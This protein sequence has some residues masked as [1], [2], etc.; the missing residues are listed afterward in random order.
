VGPTGKCSQCGRA[1][2]FGIQ[3]Y[4]GIQDQTFEELLNHPLRNDIKNRTTTLKEGDC[5]DCKYWM[6]CHGGCPLDAIIV[7][8][9]INTK[10]THCEWIKHF[11]SHYFEPITGLRVEN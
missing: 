7:N 11:L 5:K 4:G 8:G 1:G 3:S 2:D 10:S 6:I 9:N